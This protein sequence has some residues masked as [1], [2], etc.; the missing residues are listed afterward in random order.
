[1]WK[2]KGSIKKEAEFSE[3]DKKNWC[4]FH[5]SWSLTLKFPRGV[6][7][8]CRISGGENFPGRF[9]EKYILNLAVRIFS[10]I[11]SAVNFV[12]IFDH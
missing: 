4:P 5:G 11:A 10:A 12:R 7:Q 6:T 3:V 1:M 8:F 2:L 9:S